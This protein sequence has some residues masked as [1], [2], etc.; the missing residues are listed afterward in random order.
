M[1]VF[2]NIS[3]FSNDSE[4]FALHLLKESGVATVPGVYF[5]SEG[6]SS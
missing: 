6:E 4:K 1:Y 3:N 2:A 5:G